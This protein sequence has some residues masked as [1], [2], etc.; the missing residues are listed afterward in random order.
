VNGWGSRDLAS[1][2][3]AGQSRN[4]SSSITHDRRFLAI[5]STWNC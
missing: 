2:V 3:N 5:L 4:K 1:G